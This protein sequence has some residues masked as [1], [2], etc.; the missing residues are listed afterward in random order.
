MQR[1]GSPTS[2]GRDA[3]VAALTRQRRR[4][5]VHARH[6]DQR[7]LPAEGS[8]VVGHIGGAADSLGL[9]FE[10]HHRYRRF[11]RDA[12]DTAGDEAIDHRV[13]D[14]E[15]VSAREPAGDGAR[16]VR[17]DGRQQ[18]GRSRRHARPRRA[19]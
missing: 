14:D 10:R 13:A 4:V 15:N 3:G 11:G 7:R 1:D 9:M 12:G 6:G 16:P 2:D 8:D 18:H 17:R 5:L 19:A